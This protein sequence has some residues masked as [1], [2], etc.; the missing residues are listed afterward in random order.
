VYPPVRLLFCELLPKGTDAPLFF[1]P[2][3]FN[4]PEFPQHL[5]VTPE[6]IEINEYRSKVAVVPQNIKIF[7][8]SL[9]ENLIIGR[10]NISASEVVI[11][12]EDLGFGNFLSR[13]DNG[14]LTMLGKDGLRLSG[15]EIQTLGLLRALLD[16]PEIVIVDEALTGM[17]PHLRSDTLR[18]IRAYSKTKAVLLISHDQTITNEADIVYKL[19]ETGT[20]R[21]DHCNEMQ[22]ECSPSKTLRLW[23]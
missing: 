7:N 21:V 9:L 14:L 10:D 12:I 19:S 1:H 11:R 15:G 8:A 20:V 22:P 17:D 13:F 6:E 3:I 16:K 23:N 2:I 18:S 4:G 5:N